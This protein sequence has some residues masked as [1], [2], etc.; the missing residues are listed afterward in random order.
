MISVVIPAFNAAHLVGDAIRS[1]LAQG[2]PSIEILVVNDGSTDETASVATQFGAPVTCLTRV[3]GGTAA[4]R[5]TGV[6]QARGQWLA[7]LDAD[8]LWAAGKLDRQIEAL[9]A[10]P[11]LEAVFGHVQQMVMQPGGVHTPVGAPQ[12]GH[13]ASTMLIRRDAFD[14]VGAFNA[15]LPLAEAV[16]WFDRAGAAGLRLVT[17]PDVVLY[18]RIHGQNAGILHKEAQVGQ[19]FKVLRASLERRK[20]A[21]S[22]PAGNR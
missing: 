16:D 3:Q 11:S 12:P 10:D 2:H 7:F 6:A 9:T 5:N 17:L 21:T 8:D 15:E 20:K 1:I 14:R 18:R 13:T 22:D 4:A 19:Y